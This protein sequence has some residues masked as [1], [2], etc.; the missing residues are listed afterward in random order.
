MKLFLSYN[1]DDQVFVQRVNYY[2]RKQKNLEPYFYSGLTRPVNWIDE[3]GKRLNE[4]DA[5]V[6]FLGKALGTTQALEAESMLPEIG[7]DKI[8]FILVKRSNAPIPDKLQLFKARHIVQV[9]DLTE[10]NAR[11]CAQEISQLLDI[12]FVLDDDLPIGYPFDY[13]KSIIEIYV[14]GDL[15]AREL[16]LG[17]P[18]TWPE[19]ERQQGEIE[20]KIDENEIGLYR[21]WDHQKQQIREPGPRVIATALVDLQIHDP[22]RPQLTFPEAGPRKFLTYP[23]RKEGQLTVGVLVSGGIA[24][25]I[26]AVISGIVKRQFLYA[27]RGGYNSG[28]RVYGYLNGFSALFHRGIRSRTLTEHQVEDVA[29]RG[30]SL[31]GTSRVPE[32]MD[33]DP[34][35]QAE[36]LNR[37]VRRLNGDGVEILYVIGGDGSMRAGHAI[38][39]TAQNAGMP[40]SVVGIPKTMDNDILWV[41]QAF[42]FLSAVERSAQ[43]IRSLH[44][45]AKSNPRLG[46]MQLFGSDSGFV[47][48]HAALAS[49]VCDLVLIPEQPFQMSKVVSYIT[50]LLRQRYLDPETLESPYGLIVMAET[51]IP[52]DANLYLEDADLDLSE[53]EKTAIRRHLADGRVFGQTPDAL[54]SGGLKLVSRVLQREFRR[55][56]GEY[57]QSFRVFTNEPRHLIRAIEPSSSDIIFGQRLGSLAVDGAMA[58]YTDFM[59]S[60]WLTEYVMIPLPLVV[61]GRKRIPGSGIF[62]K[63]VRAETGQ[64]AELAELKDTHSSNQQMESLSVPGRKKSSK[65]RSTDRKKGASSS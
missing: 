14:R 58:G 15:S 23:Q 20:N 1:F 41:W 45:E 39:K 26:N 60:Q 3:L 40:L 34:A 42:G 64:P 62:L 44:T 54:R 37:A 36:A 65:V 21:D 35:I 25:G 18:V 16:S 38:W 28:L 47:V 53:E 51:A 8:K 7:N 17:C 13:E 9:E 57:W 11:H 30:G 55:M 22:T 31:L 10:R 12:P 49:G 19:V 4:C 59:I 27:N 43:M 33:P 52:L 24:P 46:I 29:D 32:F 61:L 50:H 6:L 48:S 5:L 2:L 56:D 63:S